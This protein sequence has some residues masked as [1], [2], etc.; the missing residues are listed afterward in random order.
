MTGN[1][2]MTRTSLRTGSSSRTTM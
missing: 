1:N 2:L